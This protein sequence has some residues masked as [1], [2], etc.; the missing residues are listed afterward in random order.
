MPRILV[1]DDEAAITTHL[2]ERL[3]LMGYQVVGRAS[4]GESAVN[5]ARTLKPDLIL[6][7]IVMRGRLDGIEAALVIRKELGIPV[8][9]LT[10][11]GDDAYISR[12]KRVEPLG[13]VIKP[14]QESAL[15]A[16]VEVALYNKDVA[17]KLKDSEEQW[18]LLAD[19]IHEGIILGDCAGKIFFWNKGAEHIFGWRPS[20]AIG[21]PI[22]FI[23]PEGARAVIQNKIDRTIA[24]EKVH[25]SR[26]WEEDVGLRSDWSKFPL[27]ISLAPWVFKGKAFF[28]CLVRDIT[29]RKK[30]EDGISA[31]LREKA[32]LLSDVQKHVESNLQA[33][34]SL[35]DLQFEYLRDKKAVNVLKESRER[36]RSISLIHEKLHPGKVPARVDFATYLRNLMHRLLE[37]FRVDSDRVDLKLD[38]EETFLDIGAAIPC[39]LI[40]S[41]LTSNAIKYAFPGGRR[42]E[43][44]V[45]FHRNPE[46]DQGYLLVVRDNG[47]GLPRE[48]DF[49]KAKSMGLQ[50]VNDLVTQL[51]GEIKLAR[52]GGTKFTVS[53]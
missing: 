18:R 20:E 23:M 35:I 3:T 12:A 34:Y 1:V 14:F 33:I 43:I 8:V 27:E 17:Q 52:R 19:N 31:S 2:E 5:S 46:A 26:E 32:R 41:E 51:H 7:D 37:A 50:I 28:I 6:M 53:F 25:W 45:E 36:I 13:Y 44:R 9:F 15:R 24:G 48:I 4:S 30:R 21:R 22:S 39:G 42:G 11:Y 16:A 47:I 38:V 49:R 10:A 40:A 29:E